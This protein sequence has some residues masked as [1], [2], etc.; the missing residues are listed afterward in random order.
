[1]NGIPNSHFHPCPTTAYYIIGDDTIT[2]S[3]PSAK[4]KATLYY[5]GQVL[6]VTVT[7]VYPSTSTFDVQ[8]DATSAVIQGLPYSKFAPTP[9]G[10]NYIIGTDIMP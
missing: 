7:Y 1:M 2:L 6:V 10:T 8:V 4:D 5:A 9:S 3:N